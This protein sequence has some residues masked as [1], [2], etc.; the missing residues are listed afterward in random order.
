MVTLKLPIDP[1][2]LITSDKLKISIFSCIPTSTIFGDNMQAEQS[3]V[4]KV[5]SS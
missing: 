2:T 4:G 5:L 3:I 1:S